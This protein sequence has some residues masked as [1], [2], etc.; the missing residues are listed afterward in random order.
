MIQT[1]KTRCRGFTLIELVITVA[2]VGILAASAFPLAELSQ[3][4]QKE[5]DLRLA[6]REIRTAIDAYREATRTGQV[7]R[8]A[9]ATG[10]PKKLDDLVRG[11]DDAK[12]PKHAKVYFLRRLPRDPFYSGPPVPAADTWGKR[13]YASPPDMPMEGED[14]FDVYSLSPGT[15]L[16]GI[17]YREW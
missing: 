1:A 12:D 7:A 3:R 16:N 4:R 2:I 8:S 13:S 6:L 14:V 5:S 15:G 11:V 9:D 10:F 17:A